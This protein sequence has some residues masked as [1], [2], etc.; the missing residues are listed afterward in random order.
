MS[1][2][3]TVDL[4]R[5]MRFFEVYWLVASLANENHTIMVLVLVDMGKP[6]GNR[7]NSL[8]IQRN[9]VKY[10]L[11]TLWKSAIVIVRVRTRVWANKRK[12]KCT[13]S[14]A[15]VGYYV[16][17]YELITILSKFWLNRCTLSL[18]ELTQTRFLDYEKNRKKQKKRDLRHLTYRPV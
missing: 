6:I 2:L 12:I 8:K 1:R 4:E 3:A 17:I 9:C 11:I 7:H 15:W 14:M 10:S 13:T 16:H 5:N 18:R